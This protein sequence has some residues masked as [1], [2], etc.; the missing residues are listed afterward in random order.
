MKKQ[1]GNLAMP[2]GKFGELIDI[3]STAERR[4][5]GEHPFKAIVFVTGHSGAGKSFVAE[6][7]GRA[8]SNADHVFRDE[9]NLIYIAL[10][11]CAA[12]IE[13]HWIVDIGKIVEE[14]T[15]EDGKESCIFVLEGISHNIKTLVGELINCGIDILQPVIVEADH[16]VYTRANRLK[17]AEAKK[18]PQSQES[19]L[20]HWKSKGELSPS[21]YTK[22]VVR[23]R[24]FFRSFFSEIG[25]KRVHPAIVITNEALGPFEDG[26]HNFT[27]YPA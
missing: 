3:L 25:D 17:F 14:V 2:D 4:N 6:Q 27:T 18:D 16:Y 10:D 1:M 12:L 7:I 8:I 26:W 11:D 5:G 13:G 21:Q 9:H 23:E 15:R 19:W 22:F 20:K 24:P